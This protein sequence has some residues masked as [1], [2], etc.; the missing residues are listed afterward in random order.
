MVRRGGK[1]Y[2]GKRRIIFGQQGQRRTEEENIENIWRRKVFLAEEKK[3]VEKYGEYL[4]KKIVFCGGEEER[5][6][7][8]RKLL[9]E[10]KEN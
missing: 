1:E 9:G 5:R 7:N 3:N 6:R 8:G 4:E 10:E 2:R